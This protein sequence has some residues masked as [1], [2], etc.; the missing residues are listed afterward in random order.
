M[1][2]KM[3]EKYGNYEEYYENGQLKR[4]GVYQN[5]LEIKFKII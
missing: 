1:E 2:Y 4:T 5:D 3:G